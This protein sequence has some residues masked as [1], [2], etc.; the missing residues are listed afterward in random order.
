[1]K[2]LTQLREEID[3]IDDRLIELLARRRA[4]SLSI[5]A[6]KNRENWAIDDLC[7]EENLEQRL[8]TLALTYHLDPL[9]IKEL[10][11]LILKYSKQVQQSLSLPQE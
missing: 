6:L 8:L 3:Q 5:G 9:F 7:R 4:L 2:T 1:M 11:S 10:F